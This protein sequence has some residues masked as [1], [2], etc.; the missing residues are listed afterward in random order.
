[1]GSLGTIHEKYDVA[2]STACGAS[3]NQL[4]VDKVSQAQHCF[5]Y[6]RQNGVGRATI[7]ALEKLSNSGWQKI[8]TPENVP[9]LFDL[10][11]PKDP[12]FIPAFWKA[13]HNT[14]V[15]ED[16]DQASRIAYQGKR[17]R[18]VTLAG[19]LIETSGAMSGGGTSVSKGYMSNK[20]AADAVSPQL[21]QRYE[22]E[23]QEAQAE[24]QEAVTKLQNAEAELEQLTKRG[25]EIDLAYQKLTMEVENVKRRIVDAEKRVKELK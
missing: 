22:R 11:K 24:L 18:V 25:P 10:V 4:V 12:K 2:I 3:L 17:W 9:R 20:L 8:N 15:A 23:N 6:L 13:I 21:L 14:L 5:E 16:M 7:I 19:G 1:M